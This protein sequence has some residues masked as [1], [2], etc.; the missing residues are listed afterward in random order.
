[1]NHGD[2]FIVFDNFSSPQNV[3]SFLSWFNPSNKPIKTLT[4][5]IFLG[6]V[7]L[8]ECIKRVAFAPLFVHI[9]V[10]L[11]KSLFTHSS[12]YIFSFES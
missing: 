6:M 12:T 2:D 9:T 7:K 8:I 10:L 1:M 5:T 3:Q 4:Y 11:L